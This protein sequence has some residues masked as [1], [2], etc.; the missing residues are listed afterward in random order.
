MNDPA[1]VRVRECLEDLGARFDRSAVIEL[2]APERLAKGPPRDVL[3]GDVDVLGIPAE[4]VRA[5]TGG[6]AQASGGLRLPLGAGCRLALPRDD[7]ES[8][9]EPVLLVSG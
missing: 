3:L 1:R 5:L 9:V 6:V 8:D 7:F 2:A 4:P